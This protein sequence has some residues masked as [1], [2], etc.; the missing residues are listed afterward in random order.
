M[1]EKPWISVCEFEELIPDTGVCALVNSNGFL[2]LFI[3]ED[4]AANSVQLG[5][6]DRIYIE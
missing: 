3:R 1:S 6:G 2:E 4:N 5:V